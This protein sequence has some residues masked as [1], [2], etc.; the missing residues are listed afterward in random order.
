M[1]RRGRVKLAGLF[2]VLAAIPAVAPLFAQAAAPSGAQHGRSLGS[3]IAYLVESPDVP[4]PASVGFVE[5]GM[6]G[7]LAAT[8]EAERSQMEWM[9]N[10]IG[11]DRL[12]LG[13][14]SD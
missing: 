13:T 2:L 12:V 14:N 6:A 1:L 9:A 7:L 10:S 5:G 4:E 3:G 11:A 8:R